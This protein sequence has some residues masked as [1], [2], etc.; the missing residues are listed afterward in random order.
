MFDSSILSKCLKLRLYV[1][2]VVSVM[3]YGCEYWFLTPEVMTKLNGVN[4]KMLER[5]MRT[6]IRDEARSVTT[7]F[8]LLKDS[9]TTRFKWAGDIL[10][11]DKHRLLHLHKIFETQLP[12]ERT[13][14]VADGHTNTRTDMS[15]GEL[16]GPTKDTSIWKSL[17][18]SKYPPVT[19]TES[20]KVHGTNSL[21][22]DYFF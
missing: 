9:R 10:R 6:S 18:G 11:M 20:R 3:T 8:D 15:L 7:H 22:L 16:K 21:E 4:S 19:V 2:A 5:F 13:R 14:G 12:N 1:A 17:R